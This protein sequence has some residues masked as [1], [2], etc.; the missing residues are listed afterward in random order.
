MSQSNDVIALPAGATLRCGP[1]GPQL[2]RSTGKRWTEEAEQ[3]F[4]DHLA[5]TA[6]VRAATAAAGF[7][8]SLVY[9]RRRNDAAFA[10]RWEAAL[11][12]G[13]ARIEALMVLRAERALEGCE[14]DGDKPGLEVTFKDALALLS[15]HSA[16]IRGTGNRRGR[17]ARPRSLDEMRDS[18]LAKLEAFAPYSSMAL[19]PPAE[20]CAGQGPTPQGLP[21]A[22]KE[23]QS[24]GEGQSLAKGLSLAECDGE[25]E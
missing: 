8:S 5:A 16:T 15:H 1:D 10:A 9:R 6:N 22:A 24:P 11:A 21:S 18:I 19:P 23:G 14:P 25:D 7:T 12:Q 4:V 17:W 2:Q 20:L 3:R 13:Y